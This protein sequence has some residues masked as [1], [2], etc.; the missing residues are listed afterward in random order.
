MCR[1]VAWV[2]DEPRAL[3]EI[4]SHETVERFRHLST[5][6]NDGWG[7]AWRTEDGE[8]RAF[9]SDAPAHAD[10]AFEDL[11]ANTRST[12]ATMHL[13]LGTAGY[14]EGLRNV[15]PF[16]ARG[17]Y[18]VHN[19]AIRPKDRI[20]ALMPA[21]DDLPC[22]SE[23]DSE[24]YFRALQYATADHGGD[25]AA[26]MHDVVDLLVANELTATSLN[27]VLIDRDEIHVISCHYPDVPLGST[28]LWPDDEIGREVIWP[29]YLPLSYVHKGGTHLVTSSGILVN[30]QAVELPN[31]V[32]WTAPASGGD[33]YVEQIAI[34][35]TL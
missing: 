19:G 30:E 3:R 10:P 14:G 8:I 20:D 17:Q 6:H 22:T 12:A 29:P 34:S 7:A 21:D 28:Q 9:R 1:I 25:V 13:R 5:V 24:R 26:G 16:E 35:V 11:V 2:S 33:P 27:S 15:H 4:A 31:F 23:T 18:F 32:T